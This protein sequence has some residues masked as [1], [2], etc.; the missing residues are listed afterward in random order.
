MLFGLKLVLVLFGP[1]FGRD[2][3]SAHLSSSGKVEVSMQ[4]LKICVKGATHTSA[5]D[6][7]I[8]GGI[9]L[10][11]VAYLGSKILTSLS[12]VFWAIF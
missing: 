4:S 6:F 1:F 7:R 5:L 10:C 8:L 9:F 12:T 3:T 11:V 2:V